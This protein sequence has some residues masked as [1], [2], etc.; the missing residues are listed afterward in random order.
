MSRWKYCSI[1]ILV[2]TLGAL[3]CG[4]STVSTVTIT[5]NQIGVSVITN[6]TFQF[7]DQVTGNTNQSATWT[8]ACAT[9]TGT[10]VTGCGTIDSSTGLYTAPAKI[11][12]AT[13]SGI[14]TLEPSATVTATSVADTTKFATA[15]VTIITGISISI[16]PFG[17][18]IGTGEHFTFTATVNNPGCNTTSNPTCLNVTWS[19]PVATT[20]TN[21]GSID[22][23]GTYTAPATAPSPSS[24]T[25]TATSIA[26]SAITATAT[27]NV[28]TASTPTVTAVSPSNAALGSLF[29]DV[30]ITGTNFL[31]TSIVYVNGLLVNPAEVTADST[32]VIRARLTPNFLVP[33]TLPPSGILSFSISQQVGTQQSCTDPTKCQVIVSPVR[34]VI[35]G[36]SPD[37]IPQSQNNSSVQSFTVNGGFFGT[38]ASPTVSA[39]YDGQSHAS[40]ITSN[41]TRQL[42]VT[43]GGNSNSQ[44]F[45]LAGLHQITIRSNGDPTKFASANL[46]VQPDA[47][48]NPPT[49]ISGPGLNGGF[50][51]GTTPNDVAVDPATGMAVVVN[52]GSNDVTLIDL[53]GTTPSVLLASLCT[54]AVGAASAP[55]TTVSGPK[56]VA[57]AHLI[58]PAK[59]I[60]LV[61]NTV[62]KT[63]SEID[64]NAKTVTW[65]SQPLIDSP[66]S[67]GINPVTGRA[68]V[69]M[70]TRPYGLIIDLTSQASP[71]ILGPV[72][73][74]TGPNAHVAVEPHLNWAL[75]TPGGSGTVSIVDLNRQTTNHIVSISRTT[76]VVTVVVQ[77]ATQA[78]PQSSLSVVTGDAIQIQGVSVS[79]DASF[80]GIYQVAAQGPGANTFSYSQ[81]GSAL[82]DVAT[83][84]ATGTVNYSKP[85]ATLTASGTGV[86]GIGINPETETAVMA[87]PTP[88]GGITLFSLIDQSSQTV[89]LANSSNSVELGASF[90][91]FNQ[92]TDTAYVL[93][94]NNST[95]SVLDPTTP[96]RIPSPT[97]TFATGQKPVALAVDPPSNRLI[98]VN[99]SDNTVWIYSLGSLSTVR[100][101]AITETNPKIFTATST[102]N[103]GPSPSALTLTVLGK[104]LTCTNNST[105]LTVRLDGT[106]LSTACAFSS[107]DRGLTATV[108]PSLLAHARRFTLDVVD[109]SG[110]V[111]NAS[112]FTVEQSIDVTGC[113]ATP[114]PAGVAIDA[115]QNIAAVTLAGCN[116]LA[117]ISLSNGT[118]QSVSVGFTPLGVAVIPRLHL[119]IVANNGSNNA[120]IVDELGATVTNTVSTD[121]GPVG[122][123]TDQDT[124]EAAVAN[125]VANT[126]TII[127]TVGGG[128]HSILTDQRPIAVGFNYQDH[129]VA[130]A[131]DPST[132]S[133]GSVGFADAG[134]TSTGQTIGIGLPTSVVYDPVTGDLGGDC[135]STT[136][137]SNSVGCFL[138]N[139][140]TGNNLTIYD[141]LAQFESTFRI[142]INPTALA[143]NYL[144]STIVST[145]TLSHTVTVGDFLDKRIRAVLTLPAAPPNSILDQQGVLQ[146]AVDIQPLTN[147]A[148]IADTANGRVLFVPVPR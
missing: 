76:N 140:S 62:T 114:F 104:G 22:S 25:I 145:N 9:V 132:G 7:A 99:Q 39:T 1:L 51:V 120:S 126:V 118:G 12:T 55:C 11:P 83:T 107:G 79:G 143:Y 90:A 34:P 147:L 60:A 91:T 88:S 47:N 103:L 82:P 124:G 44:D 5:L 89:L 24:V 142:G 135:A 45:S 130:I 117:L 112:D 30:Y 73:I 72:S 61:A 80:N 106:P 97:T 54:G 138:I 52:S 98:V 116:Q 16:S 71:V 57:V 41:T 10:T 37:S 108:P 35:V 95:L 21:F 65:V 26:D 13:I 32:S 77:A 133:N 92:L 59:D 136:N 50:P 78:V 58:N 121:S 125:S 146:F 94:T 100:P 27:V 19:V 102:L 105:T 2:L 128:T 144:T 84:N 66:L 96:K 40:T 137:N 75:S 36:P 85:V 127:D 74:V 18:T 56:G 67:V 14:V 28:E 23:N 8:L 15:T 49:L 33:P 4:S 31:S 68:L 119:A 70:N 86:Q 81:T 111:S 69:A 48:A 115:Q 17:A 141:P 123:A 148:V 46:A 93:N 42:S 122:V 43:I 110:N 101:I 87:D 109:G 29:Q 53:S 3:G 64:L 38:S 20:T 113:S 131:A 139:S 134:A 129:Q 6:T 63:L